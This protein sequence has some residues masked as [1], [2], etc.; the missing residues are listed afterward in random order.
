MSRGIGAITV[1][2]AAA[3]FDLAQ[4]RFASRTRAE[5]SAP[6]LALAR[7]KR[8]AD[9]FTTLQIALAMP[10]LRDD[11]ASASL[12]LPGGVPLAPEQPWSNPA[13]AHTLAAWAEG[14]AETFYRG[15]LAARLIADLQQG[16]S[17]LD[18]DDLASYTATLSPA[19]CCIHRG[20]TL[21][22]PGETSG[23][24]RLADM[25]RRIA[26]TM[27]EMPP[28]PTPATWLAYA[29]ALEGAWRAHRKRRA[30]VGGGARAD[31][32]DPGIDAVTQTGS[33]TS[34]VSC[35]DAAGNMVALTHT[36]LNRFGSG[37]TLPST[38]L[39]MNNA[40]SYFD[41]RPGFPTS[42][43]P[44]KR[45]NSSN[46][47]PTIGVRGAE[48]RFALGASG[49]NQIMPAVTQVAALMLDFGMSLFDAMHHARLDGAARGVLRA[50]P[51]LGH[52]VID[53]LRR[54]HTVEVAAR[55]VFPKHYA[56]V[57]AVTRNPAT[58]ACSGLTDPSLPIGAASGPAAFEPPGD[59][60]AP[61]ALRA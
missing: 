50:D 9:W 4:R 32:A 48:A 2:G 36:L 20:T 58:L 27:P 15:E 46:M 33:C 7:V 37:V 3:G 13:L 35:V 17:A 6:A 34:H 30:K 8:S 5:L 55:L 29:D 47:C 61:D 25:L 10:E 21:Y 26:D 52:A 19:S 12:F 16:G 39:L 28:A 1:P 45:I 54:E 59:A 40:V 11:A 31:G 23:G 44:G 24:A 14:G 43:A 22:T 53:A 42:L 38:G 51:R 60:E 56:C 49:G 57:S 18:H 41:P